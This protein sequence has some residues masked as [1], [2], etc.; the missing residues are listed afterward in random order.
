L[1][2]LRA[3]LVP[4]YPP[5]RI[6]DEPLERAGARFRVAAEVNGAEQVICATGFR[7]GFGSDPLLARLV[8]EH[9][10]ETVGSWVVVDPDCSV[11]GLTT[12]DR[13]LALAGIAGQ[14]AF[15]GADTLT[16][17]KYAAHGF[18]RRVEACRTR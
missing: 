17:A 5:G 10:L 11:P 8:E 3:L 4:S 7:R 14:W 9:A 12:E 13:T 18:L 1:A 2:F 6:W 15:P 16:G